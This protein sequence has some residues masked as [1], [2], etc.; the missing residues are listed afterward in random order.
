MGGNDISVYAYSLETVVA[1]KLETLFSRSTLNGRMKDYYDIYLIYQI[2]KDRISTDILKKAVKT[3]FDNRN[4]AVRPN[5]I[6]D[7]IEANENIRRLWSNYSM[8]H[9]FA[10]EIKFDDVFTCIRD[11]CREIGL[12]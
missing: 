12:I 4:L 11:L 5:D 2:N 8:K 6:L 1:E 7:L 10:E 9:S 3:V